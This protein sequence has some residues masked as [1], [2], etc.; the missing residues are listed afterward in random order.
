[1]S[2]PGFM[3]FVGLLETSLPL[4]VSLYFASLVVHLY[5][6]FIKTTTLDYRTTIPALP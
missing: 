3:G 5:F 2:E 6:C 4:C 1:M